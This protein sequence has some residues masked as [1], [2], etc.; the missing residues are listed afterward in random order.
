VSVVVSHADR[1]PVSSIAVY[2]AMRIY[3]P[4]SVVQDSVTHDE[5]SS[6]TI[7]P[8]LV[9]HEYVSHV[10]VST[11][12]HDSSIDPDWVIVPLPAVSTVVLESI[13]MPVF[14][15]HDDVVVVLVSVRVPVQII[16]PHELVRD[17]QVLLVS[18]VTLSITLHVSVIHDS[19]SIVHHERVH[20][21]GSESTCIGLETIETGTSAPLSYSTSYPSMT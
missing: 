1:A 8:V 3:V 11:K 12:N 2:P 15:I 13:T 18:Q 19:D 6:T 14:V 17:N 21:V 16:M 20:S 10:T 7:S 9:D 4:L 5:E